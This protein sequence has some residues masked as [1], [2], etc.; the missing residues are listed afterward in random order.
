MRLA[1]LGA[2]G[3]TGRHLVRQALAAGHEVVAVVRDPARLAGERP[4]P[5]VARVADQ[6]D[7]EALAKVFAGRD[8]VLSALGTNNRG[9]GVVTAV[10][11]AALDAM[12]AAGVRRVVAVSAVPVGPMPEG[13]SLAYRA[14]LHPLIGRAF[15]A[16]YRD[17][18]GMEAALRAADADWTVIRPP[19]LLDGPLTGDYRREVGGNVRGGRTI[20]RADLAH[21]MLAALDEPETFGR[22]VGVAY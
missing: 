3:G 19:R 20:A 12:A 6:T 15:R 7:A 10:T 1:V 2:T 22:P 9:A 18:A 4:E 13:E 8:A 11:R 21:A 17:L 16:V 5:D 14:V